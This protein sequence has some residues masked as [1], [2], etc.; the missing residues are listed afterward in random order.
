MNE[1]P[2]NPGRTVGIAGI[3]LGILT[4]WVVGLPLAIVSFVRSSRAG[5]SRVLGAVGVAV[6]AAAIL[7]SVLIAVLVVLP[8]A[9][10]VVEAADTARTGKVAASSTPTS[11]Q[12]PAPTQPV[13]TLAPP[14]TAGQVVALTDAYSVDGL[15]NAYWGIPPTLEGWDLTTVDEQG[16]NTFTRADQLAWLVSAQGIDPTYAGLTDRDGAYQMLADLVGMT[17][18]EVAAQATTMTVPEIF[19]QR[20][21]E[22]VRLERS[23]D[24]QHVILAARLFGGGHYLLLTYVTPPDSFDPAAWEAFAGQVSVD[25][26]GT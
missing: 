6:N 25:D 5:A 21:V 12:S 15:G 24:T 26:S 13:T 14:D 20:S 22:L 7:V 11:E 8:T 18:D 23:T 17:V 19:R 3:V 9:R 2:K 1:D 4:V 10:A 16:M